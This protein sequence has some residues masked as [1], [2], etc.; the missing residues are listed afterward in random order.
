VFSI[1]SGAWFRGIS[2]KKWDEYPPKPYVYFGWS[3]IVYSAGIILYYFN[4]YNVS[5]NYFFN[6]F[7]RF[8]PIFRGFIDPTPLILIAYCLA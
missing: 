8:N 1:Q 3:Y 5:K 4:Y 7:Q 2:T 6:K